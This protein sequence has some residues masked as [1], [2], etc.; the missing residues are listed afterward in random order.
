MGDLMD[1]KVKGKKSIGNLDSPK[2]PFDYMRREYGTVP[3]DTERAQFQWLSEVAYKNVHRIVSRGYDTTE[4]MEQGYGMT[5]VLFVNFQSR[6]ATVEEDQMLNYVMIL[7]LEDGLSMPALMSRMV[8]R[9]K[10]FLTQAAGTSIL[11]FGHAYGAFSAFG[12]MVLEKMQE[13]EA[14]GQS[15]E[16][17]ARELVA[18]RLDDPALG[19]SDL[20]LEDPAA[21]RMLARAKK[22]GVAGP[23]IAFLEAMA[24]AAKEISEAP[25]DVDLL[26]AM[27]AIMMDLGFT[28]EATW[29]II[30]ITRSFGAGAHYIEEVEREGY[31]RLGEHLTPKELYDG[32]DDRPVPPLADR[33][34]FAKPA[35]V[36]TPD[37]W[38]AAFKERQKLRG[39][40][41]AIVEEIHDPSKKTGIKSVGK[42]I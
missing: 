23:H 15:I 37:E 7:A 12:N 32:P 20:Y 9:S 3:L 21:K 27:G 36:T 11:A 25:V 4:L 6:I 41:A 13:A 39:S 26:G 31:T 38:L 8:A 40:G 10:T 18:Q 16:E 35:K 19:I 2:L 24:A 22:L 33:H 5:D 1:D 30:A 29:S 17:A 42:K 14:S 28:P 34:K